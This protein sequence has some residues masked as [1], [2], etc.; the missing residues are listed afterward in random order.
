ML[1]QYP[2]GDVEKR[3]VFKPTNPITEERDWRK[4]GAVTE[5][6]NQGH[7]GSCHAFSV[8]GDVVNTFLQQKN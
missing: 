1:I 6:K 7:C 5:N 4:E 3:V 2:K 8:T